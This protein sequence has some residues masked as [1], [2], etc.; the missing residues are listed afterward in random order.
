[1]CH[2]KFIAKYIAGLVVVYMTSMGMSV[3]IYL[4][5][6]LIFIH[7]FIFQNLQIITEFAGVIKMP[8]SRCVAAAA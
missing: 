3:H 7:L 4:L 2:C 5:I 8:W 1:M 6:L